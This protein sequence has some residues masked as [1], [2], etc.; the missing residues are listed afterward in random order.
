MHR[1][2]QDQNNLRQ[3]SSSFS[4][5]LQYWWC[6][7]QYWEKSFYKVQTW[8]S[9]TWETLEPLLPQS[10]QRAGFTLEMLESKK[11]KKGLDNCLFDQVWRRRWLVH[12]RPSEGVDQGEGVPG[13]SGGAWGASSLRSWSPGASPFFDSGTPKN[14]PERVKE[15]QNGVELDIGPI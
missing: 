1:L 14:W 8:W 13:G 5:W 15:K 6:G 4:M 12:H 7:L 10:T 3:G 11:M 9:A 2:R